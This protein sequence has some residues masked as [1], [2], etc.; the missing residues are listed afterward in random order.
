MRRRWL[1]LFLITLVFIGCGDL[2]GPGQAGSSVADSRARASNLNA[3]ATVTLNAGWNG[4]GLECAT[5]TSLSGSTGLAGMATWEGTAY[6]T[7]SFNVAEINSGE[8]TRRGFWV[9]ATGPTTF[10]YTG[11]TAAGAS[12]NL[13][14]GWNLVACPTS[15]EFAGAALIC[16]RGGQTVPL[17]SVLLS[18]FYELGPSGYTTV[19]VS[20][21]GRI[22]P[23]KAYWVYALEPVVM[24]YG[25]EE[26]YA[27][28]LSQVQAAIEADPNI[29]WVA[30]ETS[31]ARLTFAQMKAL[32]GIPPSVPDQARAARSQ[33][34]Q[35]AV[36]PSYFT[37]TNKDGRNWTTLPKDQD[38]YGTCHAFATV[39]ALE[40]GVKLYFNDP[41]LEPD[42]SEWY[43]T[44]NVD[45]LQQGS[46]RGD[47]ASLRDQGTVEESLC[48]Y[49]DIP[50]YHAPP[51]N[52]TLYKI[53]DWEAAVGRD[54]MKAALLTR[55]LVATM[56]M[57]ED[58]R[59][60]GSS[61]SRARP[62]RPVKDAKYVGLHAILIV[63]WDDQSQA[64][65]CK[66]S[67]A[68]TWG[69][70]GFFALPYEAVYIEDGMTD[71]LGLYIKDVRIVRPSPSPTATPSPSPTAT[72]SPRPGLITLTTHEFP[73]NLF[74]R[75]PVTITA[76]GAAFLEDRWNT[77]YRLN[78]EYWQVSHRGG[79]VTISGQIVCSGPT[80]SYTDYDYRV[81]ITAGSSVLY[82]DTGTIPREGGTK[83]FSVEVPQ[84]GEAIRVK[85]SVTGRNPDDSTLFTD[86]TL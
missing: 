13:R 48:P 58:F 75:I 1:L 42:L 37:W 7:G 40:M 34:G 21:S 49:S 33:P 54:A 68:T 72:P 32:C 84:Y 78:G 6:R 76:A 11:T 74:A 64:W 23:G 26:T 5:L 30:S 38:P 36:L 82:Q 80:W 81:S 27:L 28:T 55:P 12:L 43:L 70:G 24:S 46:L 20:G 77:G 2:E 85:A 4:L 62:Y 22:K 60:Y 16:K 25:T 56:R 66:N 18:T 35:A 73:S 86:G 14:S 29:D 19:D 50:T 41:I 15:Q 52:S 61:N 57:Y 59:F 69:W 31:M 65:I 45:G 79:K 8:G 10:T 51:V 53:T 44:H 47:L 71:I 67:D 9:Y 17:G 83:T 3:T 39:G 63:G